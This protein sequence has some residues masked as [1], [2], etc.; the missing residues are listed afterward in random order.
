MRS[1][2][3]GWLVTPHSY[4]GINDLD[5]TRM[6]Y[7]YEHRTSVICIL[8]H[9]FV[10][11]YF[12]MND[13]MNIYLSRT[14]GTVCTKSQLLIW[15]RDVCHCNDV[16]MGAI[17]SQIASITIAYTTVYSDADQRK[18]QSSASLA[19]VREI[20]RGP[21]NSPHKLP[22]TRKMFPFDHV[23]MPLGKR[24]GRH[25]YAYPS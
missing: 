7:R 24:S 9:S 23:I 10:K 4:P 17:A 8:L 1:N 12:L 16:I 18:H 5:T 15:W 14:L 6:K 3:T 11:Q 22:V 21:V 19:F 2:F 13:M 25:L 20:H